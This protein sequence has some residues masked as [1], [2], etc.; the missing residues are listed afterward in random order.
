MIIESSITALHGQSAYSRTRTVESNLSAMRTQLGSSLRVIDRDKVLEA[1]AEQA[2]RMFEQ[3]R[4]TLSE[5]GF[6]KTWDAERPNA[7]TGPTWSGDWLDEAKRLIIKSILEQLD[8]MRNGGDAGSLRENLQRRLDKLDERFQAWTRSQ[9]YNSGAAGQNRHGARQSPL[10][11][12]GP[13]RTARAASFG[14]LVAIL[15]STSTLSIENS[16]S[17]KAAASVRTADGREIN[18][19]LELNMSQSYY[20]KN[21][22]YLTAMFCDPL[23]INFNAASARLSSEKFEFDLNCDGEPD[24]ISKLLAG[25]GYLAVDWDGGGEVRDGSQLFGTRNGDGFADL[26]RY[27]G[28]G[29]GWIDEADDIFSK[30]RIWIHNDDGSTSLIGL[31]EAGIGAIFLGYANTDYALGSLVN[32]DGMIRSTGM[33]LFENGGAGTV[34]HIDLAI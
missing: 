19:D 18:V 28:D 26:A 6:Q 34:Q 33:F 24:Q 7:V 20:E 10:G 23:V 11:Q 22:T 16:M 27:D 3:D 32:P 13:V 8:R 2:R 17:F 29:N 30:L 21:E 4:L 9:I 14:A 31:G 1:R 12:N 25:S 15:S 5:E